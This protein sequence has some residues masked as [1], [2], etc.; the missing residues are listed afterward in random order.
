MRGSEQCL[1]QYFR[2]GLRPRLGIAVGARQGL[3]LDLWAGAA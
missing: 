2:V 3:S 1:L